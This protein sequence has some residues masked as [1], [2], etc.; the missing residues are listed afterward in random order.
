MYGALA[1]DGVV[2]LPST[3]RRS[4]RLT[5]SKPNPTRDV[6][7]LSKGFCRDLCGTLQTDVLDCGARLSAGWRPWTDP[8]ITQSD[9]PLV[10]GHGG[11]GGSY[12][13][14]DPSTGLSVCVLRDQYTP[15]GLKQSHSACDTTVE[16]IQCIQR[17]IQ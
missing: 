11:M 15:L 17:S 13:F 5:P 2:S 10:L 9:S 3:T 4:A 16:I 7:L 1:N 14:A 6:Q 8:A 12:A